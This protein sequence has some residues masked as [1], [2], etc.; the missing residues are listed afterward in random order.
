MERRIKIIVGAAVAGLL[1]LALVAGTALAAPPKPGE[2]PQSAAS[3]VEWMRQ[4]MDGMGG[5][6]SYDQMV[7]WMDSTFGAGTHDRMVQQMATG[8][9]CHDG[10]DQASLDQMNQMMGS[11]GRGGMMGGAG[12]GM[13]GGR[14]PW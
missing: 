3:V 12:G 9:N 10:F 5:N 4:M 14:L 7:R 13:M 11:S 8:G 1:V 2:T 6:G